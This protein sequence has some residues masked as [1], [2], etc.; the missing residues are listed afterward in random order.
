MALEK[1][2]IWAILFKWKY[3]I[4]L[5]LKNYFMEILNGLLCSFDIIETLE[6]WIT[7]DY[8]LPSSMKSLILKIRILGIAQW[9]SEKSTTW[10]LSVFP[11]HET[12]SN[13]VYSVESPLNNVPQFRHTHSAYEQSQRV[14]GLFFLPS[15]STN[16]IK[17]EIFLKTIVKSIIT[18]M[19]SICPADLAVF[20]HLLAW[21]FF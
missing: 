1:C 19:W 4:T 17:S 12:I 8:H 14:N 9:E 20:R 18:A 16:S 2:W 6:H 11:V 10:M 13:Q 3:W 15:A 21:S 7:T 5:F